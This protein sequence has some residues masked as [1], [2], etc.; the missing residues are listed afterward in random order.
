MSSRETSP[1]IDKGY[2]YSHA[3]EIFGGPKKAYSWMNT[4]NAILK[5]MRP[6]DFIECGT[7]E[8]LQVIV[9]ELNRIDQ[10]IF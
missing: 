9:D 10:G 5:G 4:P 8:D 6:K 7:P 1:V 3:R 2:I